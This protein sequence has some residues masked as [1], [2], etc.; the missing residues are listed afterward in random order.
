MK[1]K[2]LAIALFLAAATLPWLPFESYEALY[3]THP[4]G[5]VPAGEIGPDFQLLQRIH[6]VAEA[7]PAASGRKNCFAIRFATYARRNDGSLRVYWRQERHQQQWRLAADKLI[8]NSYRHFCPD[9]AFDAYRPYLIEVRGVDSKPGKSATLWLV[10]DTSLGIAQLSG[11][12]RPSGKSM[13]LQG[14]ARQHV[15]PPEAVRIDQGSWLVGWL[16]TLVAGVVALIAGFGVARRT[17]RA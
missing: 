7:S 9:S 15:G 13:A 12:E 14:S 17:D 1:A 5:A 16:C 4:A 8:D 2:W 3:S 6:P 11:G 10:G